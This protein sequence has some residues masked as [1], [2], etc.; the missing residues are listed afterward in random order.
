MAY[1]RMDRWFACA[2]LCFRDKCEQDR[3]AIV[4]RDEPPDLLHQNRR[5]TR[6]AK[7][8]VAAHLLDPATVEVLDVG[9]DGDHR[10][11][12]R[13][14]VPLEQFRDLPPIHKGKP[15]ARH[16]QIRP[17]LLSKPDPLAPI[18]RLPAWRSMVAYTSRVSL[19][20]SI[21]RIVLA[22]MEDSSAGLW[23]LPELLPATLQGP[24]HQAQNCSAA[25]Y[26]LENSA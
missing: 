24:R 16:H 3:A 6:L 23:V 11:V 15:Q 9:G 26:R 22:A 17:V 1:L 7:K 2:Y 14:A 8:T 4:L 5:G 25:V 18:T 21:S 20:S 12:R 10:D 19:W 13:G